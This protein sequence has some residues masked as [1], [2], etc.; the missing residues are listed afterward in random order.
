MD[1]EEIKIETRGRRRRAPSKESLRIL[2]QYKN[3]SEE[4]FDKVYEE[5]FLTFALDS[6]LEERI[7]KKLAEFETD[8]DLSELKVNDRS[9]LRNLV[10]AIIQLEDLEQAAHKMRTEGINSSSVTMMRELNSI[11]SALRK[12]ISSMQ[13]DLSITRKARKGDKETS[14]LS[15]L[16]D[17]KQKAK[18]F[19]KSKMSYIWCSKCNMLLATLWTMYPDEKK[20][21]LQ[22]V[23]NRE[24]EDGTRCG[25]KVVVT[26]RELA[27]NHGVNLDNVPEFF[28]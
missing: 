21:T 18:I 15:Y 10:Q 4:E 24:L 12:D 23:C 2:T 6:Q 22:L 28:K 19:Y 13:L 5:K 25:N 7:S 20:N 17:L 8:Y 27:E 9:V 11:M 14:V 1:A 16:E 26:T 3:M